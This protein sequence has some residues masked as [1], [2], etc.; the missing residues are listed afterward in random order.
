MRRSL[1]GRAAIVL[2]TVAIIS[3]AAAAV[4]ARFFR[5]TLLIA[6]IGVLVATP[7][8]LWLARRFTRPWTRILL[9]VRDGITSM[10]DHD[11]SVSISR[12]SDDELGELVSAYNSLG[13]LLRRQRLDINQR[14]LLLDTVIQATPLVMVLTDSAGRVVYSN[15]AARQLLYGGRKLEGL[16]FPH[17]LESAPLPLRTAIQGN[18][19]TLFTMEVEGEPQV[20]HLSMR[21]FHLNARPQQLILLKQL[22]R[23]LAAQEVRIWKKVIRVIAHELNNSLA[24]ISSLAHSGQLLA[25]DP[26][27]AQLQRVF[28]TIG[29][30]AAHLGSFI[31]GY[32]RFAKLPRPRPVPTDWSH[33]L[34]RLEGAV[35]FRLDGPL[36]RRA[37]SLDPSQIEQVLI[38][39]LKNA[40]ESGSAPEAI[41]IRV[42][43]GGEGFVLEVAD[44][45]SGLSEAVLRD[46]LL[47]FYSTKPTGSGLGLTLCREIVEAHGGRLSLANRPD[48]PGAVVTLWLP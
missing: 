20:Y 7:A 13:D 31:E 38:N 32:S 37:V 16:D 15:L 11:F 3:A 46:A 39:L 2:A 30:R 24:P 42:R 34:A 19:D 23:E 35:A 4:A 40:A 47:P 25:Q 41:Q 29:E 43:D 18:G 21:H 10:R 22:T 36:P 8:I 6:L 44:R 14:E 1:S 12:I 45:G 48:G 33:L 17:L 28:T 26:Q 5:S 27:P 9:A